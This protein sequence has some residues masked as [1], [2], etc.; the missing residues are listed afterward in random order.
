M[1]A[2]VLEAGGRFYLAKDSTLRR[3]DFVT[4]LGEDVLSQF[5]QYREEFDPKRLLTSV[6]ADR[7]GI[8]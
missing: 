4:Y 8:A 1:N 2:L 7:L 6:M 3:S 5:R